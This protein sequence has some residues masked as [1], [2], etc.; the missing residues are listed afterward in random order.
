LAQ[1]LE[2]L[3]ERKLPSQGGSAEVGR[4]RLEAA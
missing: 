2:K 4:N 1:G 3:R